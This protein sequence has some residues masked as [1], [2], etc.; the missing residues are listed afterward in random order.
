M[1]AAPSA[2][3]GGL[4][5]RT[6]GRRLRPTPAR[7]VAHAGHSTARA[8]SERRIQI[9]RTKDTSVAR[10]PS[11]APGRRLVSRAEV[12]EISP[13]TA[14]ARPRSRSSPGHPSTA[15]P[16]TRAPS[17]ALR[18]ITEA[19]CRLRDRDRR[20]RR[21]RSPEHVLNLERPSV[22]LAP[23]PSLLRLCERHGVDQPN[24][25]S[26]ILRRQSKDLLELLPKPSL[27]WALLPLHA[28]R[29]GNHSKA[30]KIVRADTQS[31]RQINEH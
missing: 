20:R 4:G 29:G 16:L 18:S 17:P 28:C 31:F 22:F 9:S 24:D 21:P 6:R 3:R 30:E 8:E 13:S 27:C 15:P 12:E 5:H 23:R 10:S 26:L 11:S 25:R 1:G 19:A 14:A 2:P 7:G